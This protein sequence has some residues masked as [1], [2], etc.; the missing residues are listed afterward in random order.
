MSTDALVAP[1]PAFRT[2]D[3]HLEYLVQNT[4]SCVLRPFS[5]FV[6]WQ[7][8]L[9][10]AYRGFPPALV[11]LKQQIGDYYSSLPKENPGSKW[12]KTS[13]GA[14]KEGRRLT[15]EQLK[16]LNATCR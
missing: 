6:S 11:C 9:T 4:R 14:L 10:L 13:L 2:D 3:S 15:P 5:F 7:G 12:P 8:V 1:S 16:T